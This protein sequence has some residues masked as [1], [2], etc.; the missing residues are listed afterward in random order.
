MYPY[1]M[2]NPLYIST[3]NIHCVKSLSRNC[4]TTTQNVYVFIFMHEKG[5]VVNMQ[6]DFFIDLGKG[7]V[8]DTNM[9][10]II[11]DDMAIPLSRI[12]FRLLYY[13]AI[14]IGKLVQSE[15][16]IRFTWGSAYVS[17][18]VLYVNINYLRKRFEDDPKHPHCIITLKSQGYILYPRK[19]HEFKKTHVLKP[20]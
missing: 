16:L 2:L 13:L 17:F 1:D 5:M 7:I 9:E 18:N 6:N 3:L 20:R 4:L 15:E 10:Q 12:Q 11:K 14:H 19:N 8:L